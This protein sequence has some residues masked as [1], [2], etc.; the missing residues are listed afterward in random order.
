[1]PFKKKAMPAKP[2][3]AATPAP[4]LAVSETNSINPVFAL[5]ERV[6]DPPSLPDEHA[7]ESPGLGE[8]V[9]T[10]ASEVVSSVHDVVDRVTS[11][12]PES[13]EVVSTTHSD[14]GVD[15]T[16]ADGSMIH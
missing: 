3:R 13:K 16:F 10:V 9:A 5:T 8:R 7:E 2:V 1:M 12:A 14:S 6:Q 15:V 11:K 4:V